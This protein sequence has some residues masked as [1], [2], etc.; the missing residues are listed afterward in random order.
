MSF[1][2]KLFWWICSTV[3]LLK[4]TT[5]DLANEP[6]APWIKQQGKRKVAREKP[7]LVWAF[8]EQRGADGNVIGADSGSRQSP[9]REKKPPVWLSSEELLAFHQWWTVLS[10][11]LTRTACVAFTPPQW[12]RQGQVVAM[13]HSVLLWPLFTAVT[14][15]TRVIIRVIHHGSWHFI[16]RTIC[17]SCFQCVAGA[18]GGPAVLLSSFNFTNSSHHWI[19]LTFLNKLQLSSLNVIHDVIH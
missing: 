4:S 3:C 2:L 18:P 9:A 19:K 7:R 17:K 16:T 11:V 15:N 14:Q 5:E 13:L 10:G 12:C 6:W 1:S 8:E